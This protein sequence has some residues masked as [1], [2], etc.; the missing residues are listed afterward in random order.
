MFFISDYRG[1]RHCVNIWFMSCESIFLQYL[2]AAEKWIIMSL[3]YI[4]F[5]FKEEGNE[6]FSSFGKDGDCPLR[7]Y[8]KI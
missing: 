6:K 7:A 2:L 5:Y 8:S 4:T 3:F 1:C